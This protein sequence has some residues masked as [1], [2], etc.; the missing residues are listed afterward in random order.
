MTGRKRG[1]SLIIAKI[2][3]WGAVVTTILLFVFAPALFPEKRPS[4]VG[5]S[6]AEIAT[7]ASAAHVVVGSVPLVLPFVAM[8]D[9]VSPGMFFSLDRDQ[10][11]KQWRDARDAFRLAA[12]EPGSAPVL[13]RVAVQVETYGWDDSNWAQREKLCPLLTREWARTVCDDPWAALQQS[14]P[15]DRFYLVDDRRLETFAHHTT[16][17]QESMKDQ[18]DRLAATKDHAVLVCD[19]VRS[20]GRRFCTS[21]IQIEDHLAVVWSVWDSEKEQAEQM[22]EREGRALQAFVRY[23]LAPVEDFPS[24]L[25]VICQTQRPGSG[26]SGVRNSP[27]YACTG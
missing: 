20:H 13:D 21:M 22:A 14:L 19:R 11:V 10:A 4:T 7:L 12:S 15:R 9:Q 18:L 1:V 8:P 6:D 26:P 3:A 27:P 24:L 2:F 5:P 23:G 16:V 25:E 17:G